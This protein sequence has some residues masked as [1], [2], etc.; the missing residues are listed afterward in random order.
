[1]WS[2]SERGTSIISDTIP[3]NK[4]QPLGENRYPD[5]VCADFAGICAAWLSW[6]SKSQ[7]A[8]L[9]AGYYDLTKANIP[10]AIPATTSV[11]GSGTVAR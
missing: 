1:M 4:S 9:T 2:P 8:G 7:R 6:L 11:A 5:S 10:S 3:T